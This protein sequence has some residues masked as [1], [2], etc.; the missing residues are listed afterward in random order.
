MKVVSKKR[1]AKTTDCIY[2]YIQEFNI[3]LIVLKPNRKESVV[4]KINYRKKY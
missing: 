3:S 1:V 2:N 4:N